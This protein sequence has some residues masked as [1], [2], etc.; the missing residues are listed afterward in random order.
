MQAEEFLVLGFIDDM[1]FRALVVPADSME[2]EIKVTK[3]GGD[4][5]L[6]AAVATVNCTA[7]APRNPGFARRNFQRA[8]AP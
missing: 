8:L 3:F 6:V 7:L 2:I 1:R 4:S 5:G